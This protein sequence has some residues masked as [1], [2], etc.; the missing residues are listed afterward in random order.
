MINLRTK[1]HKTLKGVFAFVQTAVAVNG[2]MQGCVL[3]GM[4]YNKT[5]TVWS[6]SC[7]AV[8]RILLKNHAMPLRSHLS[9]AP[10]HLI[11]LLLLLCMMH[12][13][14]SIIGFNSCTGGNNLKISL[15]SQHSHVCLKM[16]NLKNILLLEFLN[17]ILIL[18]FYLG[19]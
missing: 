15:N 17:V 4:F 16:H 14:H 13:H 2:Q 6:W 11:H 3:E 10:R 1:I 8:L 7:G 5:Q 19:M 18:F 12:Y 9:N